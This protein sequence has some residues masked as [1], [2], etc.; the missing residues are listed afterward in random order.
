MDASTAQDNDQ[1]ID[2]AKRALEAALL[3]YFDPCL[4]R[5][6]EIDRDDGLYKAYISQPLV[7]GLPS[8]WDGS[9]TGGLLR[10]VYQVLGYDE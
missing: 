9:L 3:P 1:C 4:R 7:K 8:V 10:E 2:R 5:I 6:R